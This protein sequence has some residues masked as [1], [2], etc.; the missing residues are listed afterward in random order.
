MASVVSQTVSLID[1]YSYNIA[2]SAW[3]IF[4]LF[5]RATT[6]VF[7]SF[8]RLF[9]QMSNRCR[10][11]WKYKIKSCRRTW[12][13]VKES[14]RVSSV[15]KLLAVRFRSSSVR[16][17]RRI[18]FAEQISIA[19]QHYSSAKRRRSGPGAF[20]WIKKKYQSIL[21]YRKTFLAGPENEKDDL[22]ASAEFSS[23]KD[24]FRCLLYLYQNIW[25][26]SIPA[27]RIFLSTAP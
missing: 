2:D 4:H 22:Y 24:L 1:I 14:D 8:I 7:S 19:E 15:T 18:T 5:F 3:H 21:L 17:L 11:F 20:F 6:G 23:L 12:I 9:F 13:K 16:F 27:S 26:F 25:V 10:F